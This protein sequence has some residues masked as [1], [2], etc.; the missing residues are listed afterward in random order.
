MEKTLKDLGVGYV[1]LYL[2][3]WPYA[4][5]QGDNMFPKDAAGT[6]LYDESVDYVDTWKAMEQLVRDG[7][8]KHIGLSNFNH[9]Q[10]QRVLD[11]AQIKPEVLQV[12]C[13][14]YLSQPDL[15]TFCQRH[16]IVLTAYCP[17]G[18]PDRP[19]AQPDH[20]VLLQDAVLTALGKKYGK[21][22][23][24]IAL[25]FQVE[26]GVAVIP[27]SVTPHRIEENHA[28][29]DFALSA[30][31]HA[32]V[33]ALNRSYRFNPQLRDVRVKHFPFHEPF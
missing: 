1:D 4:F 27:K 14:P 30:D 20:P 26:R 28:L 11:I 33:A 8:A 18:S 7:L 24:Q 31:D 22:P 10:V 16:G 5:V 29:F 17:L 6:M 23:A 15:L 19:S 21:S 3:H 9:K 12:E 2:I 25:R 32:A 13:H